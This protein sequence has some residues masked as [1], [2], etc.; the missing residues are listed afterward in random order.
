MRDHLNLIPSG[1]LRTAVLTGIGA[2]AI[3]VTVPAAWDPPDTVWLSNVVVDVE[4]CTS[5]A[6]WADFFLNCLNSSN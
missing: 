1:V 5:S 6:P 2:L 3:S 4:G